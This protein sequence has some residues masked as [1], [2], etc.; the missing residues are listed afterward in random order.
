MALTAT[1]EA[2][3]RQ[4]IAQQAALLSLAGNEST[5]TSKLGATKVT[6]SDL[7]AVNAV[8]DA[9]LLLMRQGVNDKS[10]T[11]DKLAEYIAL[12]VGIPTA[13]A[14][15]TADAIT[16]TYSPA[17]TTLED[18]QLCFFRATAANATTTPSFSP[19]ELTARTITMK[20]GA[21]V[22]AGAIPGALA[23]V[24]LRYNLANTR[25]ELLNPAAAA[26]I[27]PVRLPCRAATAVNITLAGGAPNTHNGV[28][29]A[30]NDRI[31]VK[32]QSTASQNGIYYV[33]TLGTGANGTWTRA[34]DADSAG[35]MF[36]GML[37]AVSEGTAN[38][39]SLWMLITN[40]PITIGTTAL[41]FEKKNLTNSVGTFTPV[42][43][44][45]GGGAP[46]YSVQYGSYEIIGTRYF[47]T[48]NVALATV[49]TLGAGTITIQG[50]GSTNKNVANNKP[51]FT[52]FATALAAGAT[53][54]I[55]AD[56]IENTST[57]RL[58]NY[59]AGTANALVDTLLTGTSV[60]RIS[61][62]FQI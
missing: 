7:I 49:G 51:S 47:F 37:V 50:I 25:W 34:T 59:S 42:I 41:T 8:A 38:S 9:D 1:E 48:L 35:D 53:T 45:S 28:T 2:Q 52:V 60:F 36:G 15:G 22:Y 40:D 17:I 32:D 10:V 56:M 3:A 44:S 26:A 54:Q 43:V 13:V 39:D 62:S 20:G 31:L 4:L 24:I 23:E 30:A 12:Q 55:M 5:I 18:G 27:E 29:L 57:I 58:F 46:T 33:S 11:A 14:G 21:A 19:N 16:A 61:G 6:L